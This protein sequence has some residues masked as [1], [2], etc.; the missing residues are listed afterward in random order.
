MVT[1]WELRK[2]SISAAALVFSI[3]VLAFSVLV[4]A[5]SDLALASS[6][7]AWALSSFNVGLFFDKAVW[8]RKKRIINKK[9]TKLLK[10]K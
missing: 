4:L 10:I 3:W 1:F 6:I 5:S 9:L 7:L 2:A 8:G